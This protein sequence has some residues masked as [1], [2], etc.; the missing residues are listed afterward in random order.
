MDAVRVARLAAPIGAAGLIVGGMLTLGTAAASWRAAGDGSGNAAATTASD[1]TTLDASALAPAELYPG[2]TGD[3]IVRLSNPNPF[4]LDVD[5]IDGSGVITS[6]AGA[7]CDAS[8][9]VTFDDR[10]GLGLVVPA[11]STLTVTLAD[12]ATMDATSD[13]ACQGAIFTIPVTIG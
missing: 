10:A 9:G 1:L 12:A 13:D 8:T 6:D 5:R 3:V 2:G 7:A 11:G 4:P